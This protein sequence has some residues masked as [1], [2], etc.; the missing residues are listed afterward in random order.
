M[1][2]E[3]DTQTHDSMIKDGLWCAINDYHMGIT[4][5]N[6]AKQYKISRQEQ[7]E[8]SL[9]SQIKASRAIQEGKFKNEILPL[10]VLNKRRKL[11]LVK[12]S[13]FVKIAI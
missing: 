13:L 3:W 11:I 10:R 4:A 5:E 1:V 6:L 8:Y 9:Y 12:M 7:D 2:T